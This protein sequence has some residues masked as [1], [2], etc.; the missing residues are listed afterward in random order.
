[1]GEALHIIASNAIY[2]NAVYTCYT[3]SKMKA[4]VELCVGL[5]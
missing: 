5:T 2:Y 3:V 4:A 1:M